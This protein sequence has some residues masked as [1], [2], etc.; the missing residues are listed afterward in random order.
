MASHGWKQE[1]KG[2]WTEEEVDDLKAAIL[3]CEGGDLVLAGHPQ[4]PAKQ[5]HFWLKVAERLRN[6]RSSEQCRDKF[7]YDLW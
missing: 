5:P 6:G 7:Q 3:E 4:R 2:R 1:A